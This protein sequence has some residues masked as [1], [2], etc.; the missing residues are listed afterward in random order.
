MCIAYKCIKNSKLRNYTQ[1]KT[2][3]SEGRGWLRWSWRAWLFENSREVFPTTT[4]TTTTRAESGE[5]AQSRS[6]RSLR[7]C[8]GL[9]FCSV[10]V[11]LWQVVAS[12][13]ESSGTVAS[14]SRSDEDYLL[15]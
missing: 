15:P 7:T 10:Q 3:V 9:Q 8:G 12:G 4:T 6:A 2:K 1:K 13:K 11:A 14:T 5:Q